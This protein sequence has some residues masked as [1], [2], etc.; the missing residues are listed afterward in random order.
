MPLC[1]PT[2][3]SVHRHVYAVVVVLRHV[4]DLRSSVSAF[5]FFIGG[6]AVPQQVLRHL[7]EHKCGNKCSS[8]T[9]TDVFP[10]CVL[11]RSGFGFMRHG[12]I[13]VLVVWVPAESSYPPGSQFS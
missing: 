2:F 5:L 13:L 4:S 12:L 7:H 8:K 3:S 11:Y 6:F 9:I 10:S 1:N